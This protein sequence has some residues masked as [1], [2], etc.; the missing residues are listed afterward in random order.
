MTLACE[1]LHQSYELKVLNS[2]EDS[3]CHCVVKANQTDVHTDVMTFPS[4]MSTHTYSNLPAQRTCAG[5]T[6]VTLNLVFRLSHFLATWSGVIFPVRPISF[7]MPLWTQNKHQ[8]IQ[9]HKGR[10]VTL[11]SSFIV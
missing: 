8:I 4:L 1:H 9:I 7:T 3:A 5:Q 10:I 11:V 2:S 6:V